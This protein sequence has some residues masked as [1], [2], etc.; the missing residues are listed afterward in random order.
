MHTT[1]LSVAPCLRVHRTQCRLRV[2]VACLSV[3]LYGVPG[4]QFVQLQP[5]CRGVIEPAPPSL[6]HSS[7]M[8]PCPCAVA[9]PDV[10]AHPA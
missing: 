6:T 9:R 4:T 7:Y 10:L 1:A 3:C 5:G 2:R 8:G